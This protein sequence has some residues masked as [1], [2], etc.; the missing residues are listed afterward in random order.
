M[1]RIL[2]LFLLLSGCCTTTV[3]PTVDCPP[4]PDLLP[5]PEDIQLRMGEDGVFIVAENQLRLKE[6]AKKL[7]ARACE[8]R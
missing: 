2:P 7:E 8:D 4:R 5:V 1:N 6:Y 3:E